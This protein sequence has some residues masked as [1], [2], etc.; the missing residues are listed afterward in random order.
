M[1]SKREISNTLIEFAKS[2]KHSSDF[3]MPEKIS[4]KKEANHFFVGITLDHVV[5]TSVAWNS[6]EL[7]VRKYSGG[8]T[9][10]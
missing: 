1:I 7:I 5:K 3:G 8:E 6:A 2:L 10:F 4:T 9:D